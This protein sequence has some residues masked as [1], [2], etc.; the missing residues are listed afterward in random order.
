MSQPAALAFGVLLG[1]CSLYYLAAILAAVLFRAPKQNG[2]TPPVSILKPVRG[3]DAQFYECIRSHAAQD[4]AEFE[5]LFAARE[6]TDPA[7]AEIRKLAAE[8]PERRIEVF[9]T[10]QEFGPNGKINSLERLR[11]ECRHAVL[12]VDDSDIRVTPDYLRRVVA[13]L[14]D[15]KVGL[16]T[17][18]YRGVPEA[19]PGMASLLEALWIAADFQPGVL[20]ARLL[21]M[22]FALGAT[23]TLT[24]QRLEEIGGFAPLAPYL[25][26][27]YLLGKALSERG[28][29]IALSDYTVETM[30]PRQSWAASWQHRLRWARTL[31]ACRPAGYAG[32]VVTFAVPLAMAALALAPAAWPMAAVAVALRF[33]AALAVGV[34]RLQDPVVA[35]F[36]WLLPLADLATFA[37]WVVSFFGRDVVWRGEPFR[38]E[39]DGRLT[40]V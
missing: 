2:F 22:R 23:M 40:R 8:F 39:R 25:A 18:L 6:E 16:V 15:P 11:R 38:I 37:A 13:P 17:C 28:L 9:F 35:R 33:A 27:D 36:F 34:G 21:G 1:A 10:E 30:L 32:L 19:A 29:E 3:V 12:L 26:D 7:V 24:R 31:R 4:Y 14:A 20:V 5:L